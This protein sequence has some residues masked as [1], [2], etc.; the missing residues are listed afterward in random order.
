MLTFYLILVFAIGSK[1]S[2]PWQRLVLS[3]SRLPVMESGQ[4]QECMRTGTRRTG[5]QNVGWKINTPMTIGVVHSEEF[6]PLEP[7][8]THIHCFF[9]LPARLNVPPTGERLAKLFNKRSR[10]EQTT[11]K[12]TQIYNALFYCCLLCCRCCCCDLLCIHVGCCRAQHH[13]Y[14]AEGYPKESSTIQTTTSHCQRQYHPYSQTSKTNL[15]TTTTIDATD[16]EKRRSPCRRT[17]MRSR[18]R[19]FVLRKTSS[20]CSES[21]ILSRWVLSYQINGRTCGC[22]CCPTITIVWQ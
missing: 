9:Q 15:G 4:F 5:C 7:R 16:E 2:F 10:G 8:A 20:M 14:G 18:C 1:S 21:T 11:S 19:H 12:E 3:C 17:R 22:C 13:G 6:V